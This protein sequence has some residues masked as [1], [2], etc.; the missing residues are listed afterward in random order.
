MP[1]YATS[2]SGSLSSASVFPGTVAL[3]IACMAWWWEGE[4]GRSAWDGREVFF[5][6]G[7]RGPHQVSSSLNLGV[8]QGPAPPPKPAISPPVQHFTP[9]DEQN[10]R[11]NSLDLVFTA[12]KRCPRPIPSR[13]APACSLGPRSDPLKLP[14]GG[15]R[16]QR[17]LSPLPPIA[18]EASFPLPAGMK[19]Q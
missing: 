12:A 3:S 4:G 1:A 6:A 15:S 2:I 9:S 10:H 19:L 8:G 11:R 16:P 5:W 17:S 13:S 14:L 18:P 7:K